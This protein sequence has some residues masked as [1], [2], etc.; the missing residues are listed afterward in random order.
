[1]PWELNLA[2][3][4]CARP[5]SGVKH[6]PSGEVCPH[7]QVFFGIMTEVND[8]AHTLLPKRPPQY[9]PLPPG[10]VPT[11]GQVVHLTGRASPQFLRESILFQVTQV[12]PSSVDASRGRSPNR[13]GWLY[14]TGWELDRHRQQRTP[15][16]V[17]VNAS[18]LLIRR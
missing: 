14:L 1:M 7:G 17:L 6:T 16:T 5:M 13:A 18:G 10:Q 2:A 9:V 8:A 15:R 3:P 12:E 11:A 4:A